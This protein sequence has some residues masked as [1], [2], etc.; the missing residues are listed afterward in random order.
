MVRALELLLTGFSIGSVK[1][2]RK[3]LLKP[4]Q[5]NLSGVFDLKTF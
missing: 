4:L 5:L 1:I 2:N 3:T